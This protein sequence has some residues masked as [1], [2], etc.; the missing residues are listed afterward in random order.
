[1]WQVQKESVSG[2]SVLG[3]NVLKTILLAEIIQW[4]FKKLM[5]KS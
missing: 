5:D 2:N 3:A 1:M 4:A